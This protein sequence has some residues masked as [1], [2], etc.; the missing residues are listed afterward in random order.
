MLL[1]NL[2][3]RQSILFVEYAIRWWNSSGYEYASYGT[4]F[5]IIRVNLKN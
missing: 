4:L 5:I 1:K 3:D 2:S